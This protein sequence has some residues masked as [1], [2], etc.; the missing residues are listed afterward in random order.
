VHD[1]YLRSEAG[2]TRH[3]PV[4]VSALERPDRSPAWLEEKR[5]QEGKT[6]TLRNYPLSAEEAFAHASE[7]YFA[8]ELVEAAQR[9]ALPSSPA[10]KGEHYLKAWDLGRKNPSVCVVLRAPLKDE[11]QVWQAVGYERLVGEDFPAIQRAIEAMH[12]QYPG[13]TVVEA[14]NMESFIQNLGLPQ[15]ELIAP[16]TTLPSKQ[17]MLTEIEI[18]LQQQ[19]LKIHRDFQQLLGELADYRLPDDSITQD[20]VVALGLAI[21][22]AHHAHARD[23][24]G[25]ILTELFRELNGLSG[26]PRRREKITTDKPV[27]GLILGHRAP[28][29]QHGGIRLPYQEVDE[30][31]DLLAQDAGRSCH[32]RQA[33]PARRRPENAG[34]HRLSP[35]SAE[36]LP[37]NSRPAPSPTSKSWQWA[38]PIPAEMDQRNGLPHDPPKAARP[39]GSGSPAT[40]NS[41]LIARAAYAH[42]GPWSQRCTPSERRPGA[43]IA[44]YLTVG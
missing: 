39:Q 14:N 5:R 18:Q 28:D 40:A 4:F 44:L 21:S 17:A 13:P 9:D 16:T 43:P 15:G 7:P 41:P 8:P 23:S 27:F 20:S 2:E 3:T 10:R 34:A 25:R 42:F 31:P 19:T 26:P 22:H 32:P 1:Y 35:S 6:R 11:V 37:R 38:Q 36:V 24:G 33:R 30:V 12:E 29:E